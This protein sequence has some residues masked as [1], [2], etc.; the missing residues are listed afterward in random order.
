M[1]EDVQSFF[2]W[3]FQQKKHKNGQ[4]G[5][6]RHEKTIKIKRSNF[7]DGCTISCQHDPKTVD[8]SFEYIMFRGFLVWGGVGSKW[9][10][11]WPSNAPFLPSPTYTLVR[12][13]DSDIKLV[14][15]TVNPWNMYLN[16]NEDVLEKLVC[17]C[18]CCCCCC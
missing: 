17:C 9:C 1:N 4:N 12:N 7:Q 16:E 18:C 15:V 13:S 10:L 14:D 3:N 11:N 5:R 6:K 2:V 8:Y